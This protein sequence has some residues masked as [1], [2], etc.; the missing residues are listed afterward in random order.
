MAGGIV[1][2]LVHGGGL[3]GGLFLAECGRYAGR[4]LRLAVIAAV[5]FYALDALCN[6]VWS[7]A[8]NDAIRSEHT[9][10]VTV[11][12]GWLRALLFVGAA[13][14][15]GLVHNY[16]RIDMIANERRS[17]ALCFLRGIGALVRHLPALLVV[18]LGVLVA[19]GL[20]AGLAWLVLKGANPLHAD[21]TG[22]ALGVFL[23]LAALTSFIRS[24][25]EVGAVQARCGVLVAP[26]EADA[27][28]SQ[29]ETALAPDPGA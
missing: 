2:R 11:A 21:A 15:V 16:A 7:T 18:E 29:I 26:P 22:L 5:V 6:A 3:R 8:H 12:K 9:Q 4:F 27:I 1:T 24:G 10:D 23:M 19:T 25:V 28:L 13:Y 14:L 17:A 20:A